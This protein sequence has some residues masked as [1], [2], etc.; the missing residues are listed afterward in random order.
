M[1][2]GLFRDSQS[3]WKRC[4]KDCSEA[5]SEG[6]KSVSKIVQRQLVKVPKVCRRL[7][8]VHEGCESLLVLNFL[9]PVNGTR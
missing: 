9:R 8:R 6:G 4:V 1:S 5:V 3:R 2:Q 7:F